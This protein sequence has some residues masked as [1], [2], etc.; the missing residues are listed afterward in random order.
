MTNDYIFTSESVTR[1]HPDK[2]CDQVSDAVVDYFLKQDPDARIIAECALSGGVMFISSHYASSAFT[3]DISAI[4]RSTLRDIG[5]PKEVFDAD[6][7]AI[8]TSTSDHTA[9]DY[10]PMDLDAMSD[11]ELDT[12]TAR[13]QTSVFGFACDQT[14]DLLPLPIWLAHRIAYRLDEETVINKLPYCCP[15][16]RS[17]SVS[18]FETASLT[19]STASLSLPHSV[20][21]AR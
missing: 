2:I 16:P 14:V 17:R 1:G 13:Q 19:V 5:Y 8:L 3:H 10:A 6:E 7:C 11:K 4:A 18:N 12:I 15:M 20:K 9:R 21:T